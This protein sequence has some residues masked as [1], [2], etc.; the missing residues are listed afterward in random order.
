MLLA[1]RTPS[2]MMIGSLSD[3]MLEIPRM[4][5]RD[6]APTAPL[7]VVTSRLG[8]RSASNWLTDCTGVTAMIESTLTVTVVFPISRRLRSPVPVVTM[9]LSV[10]GSTLSR[11]TMLVSYPARSQTGMVAV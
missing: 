9:A 2:T 10:M 8:T 3:S 4:R 7:F 5:S 11:I 1:S 6:G